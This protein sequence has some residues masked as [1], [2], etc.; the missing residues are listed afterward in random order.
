MSRS[1]SL[2]KETRFDKDRHAHQEIKCSGVPLDIS[3]FILF[4]YFLLEGLGYKLHAC[5]SISS[6][7]DNHIFIYLFIYF[8]PPIQW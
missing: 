2:M 5:I 7:K 1:F 3:S 6:V 4:I 8:T